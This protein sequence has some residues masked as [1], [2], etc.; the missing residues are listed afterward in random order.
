[1]SPYTGIANETE[2]SDQAQIS[3]LLEM[4]EK[5]QSQLSDL[6]DK[7]ELSQIA[8]PKVKESLPLLA[9]F[10]PDIDRVL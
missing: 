9:D 6:L 1:M 4:I 10:C 3:L 5:L 2:T 8:S 7:R